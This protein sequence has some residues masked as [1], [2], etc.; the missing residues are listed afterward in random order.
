[1]SGWKT[2]IILP[3]NVLLAPD[4][5]EVRS[6][7][8]IWFSDGMRKKSETGLVV[9]HAPL[10]LEEDLLGKRILVEKW[11]WKTLDLNGTKFYLLSELSVWAIIDLERSQSNSA[12]DSNP[13]K[14]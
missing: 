7:G 11:A 6:S 3:G 5:D 8:G 9:Q 14:G 4:P 1:M 10:F 12:P 13:Q 2:F